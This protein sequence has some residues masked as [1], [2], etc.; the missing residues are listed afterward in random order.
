LSYERII[1]MILADMWRKVYVLIC[2]IVK[3]FYY[4]INGYIKGRRL[5]SRRPSVS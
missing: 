4:F 5:S 2:K 3:K 1:A